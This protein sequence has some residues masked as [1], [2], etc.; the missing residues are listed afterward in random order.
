LGNCHFR[1]DDGDR[2]IILKGSEEKQDMMMWVWAELA[3]GCCNTGSSS[4]V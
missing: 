3:A 1:D 2:A 4:D